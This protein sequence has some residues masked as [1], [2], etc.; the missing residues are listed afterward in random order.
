MIMMG[1]PKA[2]SKERPNAR[3]RAT[4]LILFAFLSSHPGA[5]FRLL[6]PAARRRH[7]VRLQATTKGMDGA[8]EELDS[9]SGREHRQLKH[10]EKQQHQQQQHDRQ[11][12][13]LLHSIIAASLPLLATGPERSADAA[14]TVGKDPD[15]TDAACLGV[16]DGL[17][18]DCPHPMAPVRSGAGCVSSQDDTPGNFAEPWDYSETVGVLDWQPQ[19]DRLVTAIQLVSASRGEQFAVQ[20][21][22]GRY[23]RGIFTDSGSQETSVGE[24]YF[25]PDDTT[26]QFRIAS[27]KDRGAASAFFSPSSLRNI[28]RAESIRKAMGYLKL[29]VLRNRRRTLFFGESDLDTFGPGSA[30]L[31][32]PAE[33]T[34]GELEGRIYVP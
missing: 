34:T 24:F 33:M 11:R 26:V 30:A 16:W 23:L 1:E 17:L 32:P 22:E 4:C 21:R 10:Q 20:L 25:T 29:P 14:E 13:H 2:S 18:A 5:S 8:D 7:E 12:R 15:C 19:M 27:A 6:A 9:Y 28:N 31:G 3:I